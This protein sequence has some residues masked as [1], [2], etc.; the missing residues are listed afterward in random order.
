MKMRHL[1]KKST[2][3]SLLGYWTCE[4]CKLEIV[5]LVDLSTALK[6]LGILDDCDEELVRRV[7]ES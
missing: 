4:N 2:D 3:S 1:W 5:V 7:L 6:F